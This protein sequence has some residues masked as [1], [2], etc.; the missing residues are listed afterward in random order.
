[1]SRNNGIL[2][3]VDDGGCPELEGV[4]SCKNCVY[5][6]QPG[7]YY[8]DIRTLRKEEEKCTIDE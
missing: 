4:G 1:M 8:D 2:P 7:C 5:Y 3:D 6:D